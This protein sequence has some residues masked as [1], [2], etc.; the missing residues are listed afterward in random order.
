MSGLLF[1]CRTRLPPGQGALLSPWVWAL[2]STTA[3]DLHP[4]RE[5]RGWR[6]R[7]LKKLGTWGRTTCSWRS[8]RVAAEQA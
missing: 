6:R 3:F 2:A 1:R 7:T 8:G 5:K 4:L